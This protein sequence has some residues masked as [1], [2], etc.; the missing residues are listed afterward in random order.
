MTSKIH[1][2]IIPDGNRR[3]AKQRILQPWKG[4]E[5]GANTFRNL[6]EW[7]VQS[8]QIGTLTIWGFSTENWNRSQEETQQLMEIYERFI[9]NEQ[10]TLHQHKIR[11]LHSGRTDRIPATL[12]QLILETTEQTKQYTA[13]NLH[14]ALD[15]GGKDEIVRA[16]NRVTNPADITEENFPQY[17]DQPSLPDIDLVIRTSGEQRTSGFFIWQAAYAEWVFTDKYF[18]DL[19]PTDLEAAL[20][21]YNNRQRR[22]GK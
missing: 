19:Q 7:C 9:R 20:K 15:Y 22:F 8:E 2:G 14:V 5:A 12:K 6:L 11:F 4:H 3:W 1:L 18:P 13:F 10:P 17:L 16:I 21:D